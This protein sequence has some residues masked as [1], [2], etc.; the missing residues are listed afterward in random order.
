MKVRVETKALRDALS[1]VR[2]FVPS[3]AVKDIYRGVTFTDGALIAQDGVVGIR[4]A[5]SISLG[6]PFVIN[7]IL[8]HN[9]L[10][11]ISDDEVAIERASGGITARSGNGYWSGRIAFVEAAFIPAPP[12]SSAFRPVP[13]GLT[14]A[15]ALADGFADSAGKAGPLPC[16]N[17][18]ED[19]IL[20]TDGARAVS[21]PGKFSPSG[22]RLL[23]PRLR[24]LLSADMVIQKVAFTNQLGWFAASGFSVWTSLQVQEYP[25]VKPIFVAARKAAKGRA[26][27]QCTEDLRRVLAASASAG[28]YFIRCAISGRRLALRCAGENNET[29]LTISAGKATPYQF[30]AATDKLVAIAAAFGELIPCGDGVLYFRGGPLGAEAILMEW[31]EGTPPPEGVDEPGLA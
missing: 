1:L 25:N 12:P 22:S 24:G 11:N 5:V 9:F 15:L 17:I 18:T 27:I 10:T 21:V 3:A 16:V 13:E 19:G 30:S 29:D 31:V 7:G 20:A 14:R 26:A 6:T 8:L 4:A 2:P 23:P 28:G